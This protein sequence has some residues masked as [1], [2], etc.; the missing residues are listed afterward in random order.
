MKQE[1]DATR[2]YLAAFQKF[3]GNGMAS[4]PAWLRTLRQDA[5]SRFAET[6]FPT[7]R[8]EEWRYTSLA[9][10]TRLPFR[11]ALE[12][13]RLELSREESEELLLRRFKQSCLVF[14]DGH[15]AP[16]LSS[17]LPMPA[18]VRI[19][20]LASALRTDGDRIRHFLARYAR[21]DEH[22]FTA[23]NGAFFRDGAYVCIPRG[24]AV[25][26]PIRL[27][28]IVHPEESGATVHARNLIVLEEG[29]RAAF[30]ERYFSSSQAPY[31]TNAVTEITVG[32]NARLEYGKVIS[33]GPEAC[34]MGNLQFHQSRESE[35]LSHSFSW[36]ARFARNDIRSILDGE[37]IRCLLNGLYVAGANQVVDHHTVIDHA[38]PRCASHQFYN[39]IL[40][41]RARG[42]FNGK[43]FVRPDAQKTD[44]KQTNRNLLLSDTATI[45]TKPQLE[46]FA[47]DVKCTHGAT[48]GHLDEEAIF[49]L[50]SRGIGR[51]TARRM[52]VYAFASDIINRVSFE[53]VRAQ[54]D[55]LLLRRL[56]GHTE[57]VE[58]L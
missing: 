5:I 58:R 57:L 27:L 23:L 44:A 47:D 19:G 32:A 51:E 48:V 45:D 16:D 39:G 42:V 9:P 26:D 46:I 35:L 56:E 22:A 37:G 21:G 40:G 50:R 4:E 11:P 30:S 29:C 24:V 34:H 28:F 15:F 41:G 25:E 18:G 14:V 6:G 8:H 13:G 12:P 31:M 33:E 20:N 2:P 3:Q 43:I 52:L 55:R 36:D 10:I 49:Y 53:P 7:L 17:I 38:K 54:L 1:A